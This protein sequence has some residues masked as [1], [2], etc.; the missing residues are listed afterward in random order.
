MIQQIC[1]L[2]EVF[3]TEMQDAGSGSWTFEWTATWIHWRHDS[4]QW[5]FGCNGIHTISRMPFVRLAFF[6]SSDYGE[7]C[8]H[9][10]NIC[11]TT[12]KVAIPSA[13]SPCGERIC[14]AVLSPPQHTNHVEACSHTFSALL[15][16]IVRIREW[17]IFV[18]YDWTLWNS[19]L[20][21]RLMVMRQ[22]KE[23]CDSRSTNANLAYQA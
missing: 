18:N 3:F 2:F 16:R 1:R 6:Q 15:K 7:S 5:L 23:V 13:F 12:E 4:F 22:V 21:G 11:R 17:K 20:H 8:F 9:L 10:S 19:F 14:S